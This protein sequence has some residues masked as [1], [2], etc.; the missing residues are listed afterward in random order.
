MNTGIVDKEK[1]DTDVSQKIFKEFYNE[2]KT[3]KNK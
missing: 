1:C 2:D 3:P